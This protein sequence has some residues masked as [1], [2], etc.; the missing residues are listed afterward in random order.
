MATVYRYGIYFDGEC[1][2]DRTSCDDSCFDTEDEAR[3]DAA[4]SIEQRIE[5]W[6]EDGAY[7]GETALDFYVD[8]KEQEDTD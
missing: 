8:I 4:Y 3:E 5:Q 6:K 1:I 2:I 7:H